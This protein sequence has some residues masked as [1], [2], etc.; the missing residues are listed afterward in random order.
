[1]ICR[2][3]HIYLR[4]GALIALMLLSSCREAVKKISAESVSASQEEKLPGVRL[5]VLGTVQDAGS[6]QIGCEKSCCADLIDRPD[7]NRKIISLGLVD[8]VHQKRFLIEATPD[9]TSQLSALNHKAKASPGEMPDGVFLT[10]AH[11][12]HYTGL[13]SFGKEAVNATEVPV[14]TMQRM[15]GFLQDNGPWG[16]LVSRANILLKTMAEDSL[17]NLTPALSVTPIKVP[18]RDEYSETVGFRIKG[19]RKEALFIPDIDKWD[20]WKRDITAMVAE[21][22]YAFLDATFFSGEEINSRD[23]SEIPHPFVIESMALFDKLPPSEKQKIY[24]IHFNHTNP[25]LSPESVE[26]R[27]VISK[28]FHVARF[29]EEFEL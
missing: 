3:L 1:M 18:H 25:L 20:Q 5:I 24:F 2:P 17:I 14:Y 19:V 29:G 23:I 6:P 4:Y 12:G 16:Q 22:D 27:E 9:I 8:E 21:V 7:P 11:I 15:A 26:Y 13:M 10:H 28:G